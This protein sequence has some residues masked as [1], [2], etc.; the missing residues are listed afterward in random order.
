MNEK[1]KTM[2]M[3]QRL[4]KAIR[5][6]DDDIEPHIAIPA[7]NFTIGFVLGQALEDGVDHTKL[8]EVYSQVISEIDHAR[9]TATA[10][11]A[12]Y[13]AIEKAKH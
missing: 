10:V 6:D 11:V 9:Q 2:R 3:M 5:T 7:L 13:D 8:A 4:M 1:E 12:T